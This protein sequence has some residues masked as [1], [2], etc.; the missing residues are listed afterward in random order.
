M[1]IFIFLIVILNSALISEEIDSLNLNI[2]YQLENKSE[3]KRLIGIE[4]GVGYPDAGF[5]ATNI[6]LMH[7]LDF[8]L[9]FGLRPFE[10]KGKI[11][12]DEI[13]S[14]GMTYYFS[15]NNS[16]NKIKRGKYNLSFEFATMIDS[17]ISESFGS[18]NF[19]SSQVNYLIF[20]FGRDIYFTKDLVLKLQLG[21]TRGRIIVT[22]ESILL[23]SGKLSLFYWIY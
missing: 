2:D 9:K 16:E 5:I 13:Y 22:N 15:S 21:I 11:K 10:E 4:L 12:Y 23:P 3:Y 1:K 7:N 19:Y 17:K 14:F 20:R 18:L 8:I 6:W